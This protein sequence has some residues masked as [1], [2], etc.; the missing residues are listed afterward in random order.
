MRW[1]AVIAV[2]ALCAPASARAAEVRVDGGVLEYRGAP[3]RVSNTTFAG[4]AGGA[5]TITRG[6]EDDDELHPGAG[7]MTV[8][9]EVSCTGADRAEIDAGDM[10]DR[11]TA[12][13]LGLPQ[14]IALGVGNDAVNAGAGNDVISGGDGND[15]IHPDKGTDAIV[16][17]DGIDTVVYGFRAA[18]VFSLDG[19]AN[20]GEGGENDLIGADVENVEASASSGAATL[21]GDGRANRLTVVAGPGDITGGDGADVLEG[22]PADDVL[23]AADG[24]P[25]TVLCGGGADTVEAD[26]LDTVSTSCENVAVVAMPGG[27][28]DDRPPLIAWAAPAARAS[29]PA[30]TPTTVTVAASDDRGLAGVAFFAGD[31]LLCNDAIPPYA[32]AFQPHA[33]DVG[34]TTLIAIAADTATQTTTLIR[35]VTV[36][37]FRSPGLGLTLRRRGRHSIRARGRLRRPATLT[38]RCSGRVTITARKGRRTV[39]RRRDRLSRTCRYA[40]TLRVRGRRARVTA[41]FGGNALLAPRKSRTRS[42]RRHR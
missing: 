9:T 16:G 33:A 41:R 38:E 18:P 15:E 20:D 27:A 23:H 13:D 37:R 8:G 3:G 21:V 10:S 35:D 29:L 40:A 5:V 19:V 7:C 6:P 25:D 1:P 28:F 36:R 32:C 4:A 42:I 31:R 24:A 14:T 30:N 17:G 2:L 34:R 12:T 11:I 26:T 22:G 39:A